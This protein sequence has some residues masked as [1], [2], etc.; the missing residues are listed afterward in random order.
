MEINITQP[1]AIREMFRNDAR[2]FKQ[3]QYTARLSKKTIRLIGKGE[4]EQAESTWKQC[5]DSNSFA[6]MLKS[7]RLDDLKKYLPAFAG[8]N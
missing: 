8:S 7:N 2:I 3:D 5:C 4:I 1:L 6:A